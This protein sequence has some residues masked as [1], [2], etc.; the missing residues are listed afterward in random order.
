MSKKHTVMSHDPL[1]ALDGVTVPPQPGPAAIDPNASGP[2]D[3]V[4]SEYR[5]PGSLTIAEV[6]EVHAH[7]VELLGMRDALALNGSDV[8]MIDGAGM[9]LLAALE[10]A[11]GQRGV[12]LAWRDMPDAVTASAALLGMHGLFGTGSGGAPVGDRG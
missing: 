5:L 9:Q 6:A 3:T 2:E 10:K 11:A 8:E 12:A 7:L 1:A 4:D